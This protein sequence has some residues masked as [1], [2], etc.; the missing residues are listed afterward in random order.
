MVKSYYQKPNNATY[1]SYNHHPQHVVR[2]PAANTC[3]VI[4]FALRDTHM[5]INSADQIYHFILILPINLK[6][7]D[8]ETKRLV[9]AI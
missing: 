2:L 5:N 8:A 9:H 6:R 1:L 7:Q 3:N 4:L